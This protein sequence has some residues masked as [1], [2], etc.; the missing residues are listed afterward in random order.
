MGA[1][2]QR[3]NGIENRLVNGVYLGHLANIQFYG[4]FLVEG[5]KMIFDYTKLEVTLV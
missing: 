5:K 3:W 2:A 1:A 4:P